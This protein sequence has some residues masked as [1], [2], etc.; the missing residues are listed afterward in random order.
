MENQITRSLLNT[1]TQNVNLQ[2]LLGSN[3][4]SSLNLSNLNLNDAAKTWAAL[5]IKLLG[6]QAQFAD[7]TAVNTSA[8]G[9]NQNISPNLLHPFAQQLPLSLNVNP[10][11]MVPNLINPLVVPNLQQLGGNFTS[12]NSRD[13]EPTSHRQNSNRQ[14]SRSSSGSKNKVSSGSLGNRDGGQRMRSR[15]QKEVKDEDIR[16][17]NTLYIRNLPLNVTETDLTNAFEPFGSIKDIR[18]NNDKKTGR[19]FGAVFLEYHNR[20]AARLAKLQMNGKTWGDRTIYVDYAHERVKKDTKPSS[21]RPVNADRNLS[22]DRNTERNPN[23]SNT[24][25]GSRTISNISNATPTNYVNNT[26]EE[27]EGEVRNQEGDGCRSLYVGGLPFTFSRDDIYQLFERFGEILDIRILHHPGSGKF[28]GVAF[29]D[30]ALV[31]SAAAAID[32][33]NGNYIQGRQVKVNYATNPNTEKSEK[34][35]RERESTNESSSR[36]RGKTEDFEDGEIKDSPFDQNQINSN[37]THTSSNY[38]TQYSDYP[39]SAHYNPANEDYG[40]DI[41][42]PYSQDSQYPF[43]APLQTSDYSSYYND[44]TDE[45]DPSN[46]EY[47]SQ[48]TPTD[49][50]NPNQ[51]YRHNSN[52]YSSTGSDYNTTDRGDHHDRFYNPLN[53]KSLEGSYQYENNGNEYIEQSEYYNPNHPDFNAKSTKDSV[54]PKS[55][56]PSH[57]SFHHDVDLDLESEIPDDKLPSS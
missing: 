43:P 42:Q 11:V 15:S 34:R 20:S 39:N 14:T 32:Q 41:S 40:Q 4:S 1:S 24:D 45:Q 33:L 54:T 5:A 8:I 27:T 3:N 28:K 10:Q 17:D 22:S 36:K 16:S 37:N 9:M 56:Y 38:T 31:E 30:F 2:S 52:Y 19:F 55:K 48:A 29:V 18:V 47:S 50:Y 25:G 26:N 57:S 21:D 53:T 12:P 7:N 23:I 51:S 44:Q 49:T 13:I 35:K 46:T 6:A